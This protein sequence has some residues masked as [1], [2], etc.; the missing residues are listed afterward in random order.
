MVDKKLERF[1][2]IKLKVSLVLGRK[3]LSL[4]KVLKL[5][6]GDLITLDTKVEDYLEIYLNDKKFGIG[7]LIVINDKI[8]LRLVDLV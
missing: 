1:K 6:E 2:D 5:K 8:G 4:S 7:E 3:E